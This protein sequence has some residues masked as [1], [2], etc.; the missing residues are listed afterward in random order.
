MAI[1]FPLAEQVS[2]ARLCQPLV[3]LISQLAWLY[4]LPQESY[5]DRGDND[6]TWYQCTTLAILILFFALLSPKFAPRTSQLIF[7]RLP[8]F[9]DRYGQ[10][11]P[12]LVR[13]PWKTAHIRYKFCFGQQARLSYH[14]YGQL[15]PFLVFLAIYHSMTG[16]PAGNLCSFQ[17]AVGNKFSIRTAAPR[18][19]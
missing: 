8:D 7:P 1:F 11:R 13:T 4:P 19:K 16:S 14:F 17:Q 3:F 10:C 5:Q 12:H 2:M 18:D 6:A 9:L 15:Q